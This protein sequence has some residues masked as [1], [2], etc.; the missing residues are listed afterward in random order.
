MPTSVEQESWARGE[1]KGC[2]LFSITVSSFYLKHPLWLVVDMD[3][4]RGGMGICSMGGGGISTPI[5]LFFLPSSSLCLQFSSLLYPN[6]CK[7]PRSCPYIDRQSV[8]RTVSVVSGKDS[9]S[10]FSVS[11]MSF[12]L[13][14]DSWYVAV[15]ETLNFMHVSSSYW[16]SVMAMSKK[17]ECEQTFCNW[18]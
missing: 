7:Y 13:K 9:G 6:K 14:E 1:K 18:S 2:L 5:T 11:L 4:T 12:Q 3:P 8:C 15:S 17:R 16:N 10:F